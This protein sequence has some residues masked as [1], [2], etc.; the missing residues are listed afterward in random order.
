M[1]SDARMLDRL[2]RLAPTRAIRLVAK[3][4]KDI[5]G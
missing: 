3:Q 5:G 1:R 4:M 2:G